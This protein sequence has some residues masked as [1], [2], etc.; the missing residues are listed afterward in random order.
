MRFYRMKCSLILHLMKKRVGKSFAGEKEKLTFTL[1]GISKILAL[2]QMKLA[3]IIVSGPEKEREEAMRRLEIIADTA[4]SVSTPIQNAFPS[5]MTHRKAVLDE[6][7]GRILVNRR[8]LIE[9]F[10][11][12]EKIQVLEAEAGWYSI[13]KIKDGDEDAAA[14]ELLEKHDVFTHPGYFFDFEDGAHLVLSHI[15]PEG[16]FREAVGRMVKYFHG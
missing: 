11:K 9:C 1:S 7:R 5:W 12:S 8:F 6:I 13:L 10:R 16:E 2:P 15:L 3:W 14:M 4:L